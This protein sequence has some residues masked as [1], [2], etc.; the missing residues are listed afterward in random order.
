MTIN[1]MLDRDTKTATYTTQANH[2]QE[3]TETIRED[4]LKW[5]NSKLSASQRGM[6]LEDSFKQSHF[7]E[8][9]KYALSN[10]I[11]R[12]I[13]ANDDRV[14]A[15]YIYEP[16]GNP[17]FETEEALP[18]DETIHLLVVVSNLSAALES[19]IAS[20]DRSLAERLRDLPA[21]IFADCNWILDAK[22][23]SA[24]D[25]KRGTGYA[26]LL[27]SIFIPPLKIWQRED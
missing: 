3:M 1:K 21:P 15:I 13:S 10:G 22:F 2:L 14:S 25:I 20:L 23:I 16:S 26:G 9:F 12:A 27:S 18:L 24:E 6:T 17:D 11:A 8:G 4:A 5:A 7:I 19:F